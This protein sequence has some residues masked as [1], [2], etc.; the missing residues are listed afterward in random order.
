MNQG[1]AVSQLSIGSWSSSTG[2]SNLLLPLGGNLENKSTTN[3]RTATPYDRLGNSYDLRWS[4]TAFT[5]NT[6]YGLPTL[7]NAAYTNPNRLAIIFCQL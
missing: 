2:D 7:V 6:K 5:V 1:C 4:L 3:P